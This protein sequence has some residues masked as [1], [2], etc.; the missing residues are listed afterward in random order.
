MAETPYVYSVADDTLNALVDIAVLHDEAVASPAT[1][2]FS[3]PAAVSGDV[4]TFTTDPALTGPE[5]TALDAT[6]AAHTG[7][8]YVATVLYADSVTIESETSTSYVDVPDSEIPTGAG[9]FIVMFNGE[10]TEGEAITI[11]NADGDDV[12]NSSRRKHSDAT[13]NVLTM[14]H[15]V[16]VTGADGAIKMRWKKMSGA[17]MKLRKRSIVAWPV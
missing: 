8:A 1:A 3:K 2:T 5:E 17:T 9:E 13:S 7:V 16:T 6:V 10:F 4:I 14:Q 15:K 12:V 11:F